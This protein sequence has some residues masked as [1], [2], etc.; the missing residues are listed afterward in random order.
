MTFE[1]KMGIEVSNDDL[2]NILES[3]F[4]GEG[5]TWCAFNVELP[6]KVDVLSKHGFFDGEPFCLHDKAE[7]VDYSFDITMLKNGLGKWLNE[8]E[9]NVWLAT[10]LVEI[11]C[12]GHFEFS[13]LVADEII[14][15]ALF[16][17]VRY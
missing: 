3:A 10:Q 7:N 11:E 5:T 2:E 1:V 16:G 15:Y 12:G 8:S 17:E 6:Q 13:P 4:C 9:N 14:Q